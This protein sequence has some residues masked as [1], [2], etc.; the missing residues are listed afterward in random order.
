MTCP[1]CGATNVE[2]TVT[3]WFPYGE[4][5]QAFQATFPAMTCS[6]CSF[7]WRD[8][9]A[10]EAI[11]EAREKYIALTEQTTEER[12]AEFSEQV[13]GMLAE[14][15]PEDK[16]ALKEALLLLAAEL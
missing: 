8:H 10:E 1:N 13:R 11:D 3:K 16:E 15:L 14:Q 5:E 9:R 4:I 12:V 7:D 6:V 2:Q